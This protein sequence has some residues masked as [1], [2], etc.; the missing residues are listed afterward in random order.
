MTKIQN[1]KQKN[2]GFVYGPEGIGLEF[3][4]CDFRHKTPRQSRRPRTHYSI[5]PLFHH[6]NRGE[7][8]N[9]YFFTLSIRVLRLIPSSSAA[10]VLL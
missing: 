1:P 4:I 7:A 8:P 9:L 3:G 6:S 10:R 2:N 5:I